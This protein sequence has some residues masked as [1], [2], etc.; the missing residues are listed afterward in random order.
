MRSRITPK[1]IPGRHFEVQYS[2]EKH[3]RHIQ[4]ACTVAISGVYS[5]SRDVNCPFDI[6]FHHELTFSGRRFPCPSM[7]GTMSAPGFFRLLRR[8]A[9]LSMG[10]LRG[11]EGNREA[12]TFSDQS[13]CFRG[14]RIP[15][16]D[17]QKAEKATEKP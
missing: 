2:Y 8:K 11:R 16:R 7:R 12:L 13:G 17:A 14:R 1:L 3:T 6:L 9:L 10:L 15:R 4:N 5:T